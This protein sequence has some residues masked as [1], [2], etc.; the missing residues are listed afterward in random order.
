[1][2]AKHVWVFRLGVQALLAWQFCISSE[3]HRNVNKGTLATGA[4]RDRKPKQRKGEQ[5]D[6]LDDMVANYRVKYFGQPA[7]ESK[8]VSKAPAG[9]S[10][11]F[12]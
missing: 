9:I 8:V 11:W 6:A 10:R 12:E 5:K 1:M 4:P 7:S 2:S 3:A